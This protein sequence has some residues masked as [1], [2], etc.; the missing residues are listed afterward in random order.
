MNYHPALPSIFQTSHNT[1][2]GGENL[3]LNLRNI[4]MTAMQHLYSPTWI[5]LLLAPL[6]SSGSSL[7]T[8]TK[9]N[10]ALAVKMA[11]LA[12]DS[13]RL[14]WKH[15]GASKHKGSVARPHCS[16]AMMSRINTYHFSRTLRGCVYFT[17][18]R[19][20]MKKAE[21]SPRWPRGSTPWMNIY[22]RTSR[23]KR[24]SIEM[25]TKQTSVVFTLMYCSQRSLTS[26]DWE[27]QN[28]LNADRLNK[29]NLLFS[30]PVIHRMQCLTTRYCLFWLRCACV[31][32]SILT[33]DF[34]CFL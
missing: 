1:A 22:E 24:T 8:R 18:D 29:W 26:L 7:R 25:L 13:L 27:T 34:H 14:K 5:Q 19:R 31:K 15:R 2:V 9:N 21:H 17:L 10:T 11:R 32:K 12:S 23:S 33:L 20:F 30:S 4:W 16:G 28:C 3:S 6:N